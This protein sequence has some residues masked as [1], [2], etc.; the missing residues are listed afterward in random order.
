MEQSKIIDTLE[1]YHTSAP[2]SPLCRVLVECRTNGVCKEEN[3]CKRVWRKR[4][5]SWLLSMDSRSVRH[6][7]VNKVKPKGGLYCM[8][9][10]PNALYG[11]TYIAPSSGLSGLLPTVVCRTLL[12]VSVVLTTNHAFWYWRPFR[13]R[14]LEPY[15][16]LLRIRDA[17]YFH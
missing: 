6:W 9:A 12:T 8:F 2:L 4:V 1:T 14:L 17:L 3:S 16:T 15:H 7:P 5:K 13:V 10:A 11:I